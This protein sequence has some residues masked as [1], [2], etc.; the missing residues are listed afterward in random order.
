M[1]LKARKALE[2]FPSYTP[3]RSLES[4]QREYG[5]EKIIKLAGNENNLGYSPRAKAVLARSLDGLSY[6][7]DPYATQLR[8]ALAQ[9]LNVD[10]T[11]LIFGA[12]SF[13]LIS[14][15][16]QTFINPGEEAIMAE[17]SFG[18]YMMATL[19]V[20]GKIVKVPLKNHAVDLEAI[21]HAVTE[22]TRVIWLC[23]PNNPTGTQFDG[24]SFEHFMNGLRD[25]IVVVLDE[26]YIDFSEEPNIANGLAY[27]DRYPNVVA[28]RTFSKLYGLASFRIGYGIG[29]QE[30]IASMVKA[31]VPISVNHLAQV[32]AIE[33]LKD[34]GFQQLVL[35][36]A[37]RSKELYYRRLDALNLP[38]IKSNGNFLMFDLKTDSDPVVLS[39]LKKGILLRG[40]REFGMPTWLRV[41]IGKYEENEL[42][43]D[44][45]ERI[46]KK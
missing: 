19:T 46:L 13:S 22:K 24:E 21:R 20:D 30:L 26:A 28:L 44:L 18:W 32:A 11:Q 16:A 39:F 23:N 2:Q 3:A 7:P 29:S 31:Q 10:G 37:K 40:G 41:S 45:L 14:L 27:I 43:L 9:K 25:D 35:E 17:P 6:Y 1:A 4:I 42:V 36:N 5:F 12:G 38:Y 8:E 33:S 34:T 15:V